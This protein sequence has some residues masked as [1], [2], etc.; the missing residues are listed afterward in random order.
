MSKHLNPSDIF[1]YAQSR[2]LQVSIFVEV[3]KTSQF[4]FN[5]NLWC[6]LCAEN[7]V[8][9]EQPLSAPGLSAVRADATDVPHDSDPRADELHGAHAGEQ[10]TAQ[11]HLQQHAHL[12]C[13]CAEG[14]VMYK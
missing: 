10:P 3:E 14:G 9:V 11:T 1:F 2:L 7:G 12:L 8:R 6:S 13:L 5:F 4:L